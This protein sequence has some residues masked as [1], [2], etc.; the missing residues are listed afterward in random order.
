MI[1]QTL[2]CSDHDHKQIR[3]RAEVIRF[4]AD[5]QT[6]EIIFESV[7]CFRSNCKNIVIERVHLGVELNQRNAITNIIQRRAHVRADFLFRAAQI[8]QEHKAFAGLELHI[9]LFGYIVRA[10]FIIALVLI[11]GLNAVL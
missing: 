7:Q 11:E 8:L 5:N 3:A 10:N 9:L 4:A 1:P 2:L 6:L